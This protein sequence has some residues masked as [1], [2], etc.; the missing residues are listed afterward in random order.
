[1]AMDIVMQRPSDLMVG[2]EVGSVKAVNYTVVAPPKGFGVEGYV[3]DVQFL[4]G[5]YGMREWDHNDPVVPVR[6]DSL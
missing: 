1:M 4:D 6:A 2:D 5:G 3:V